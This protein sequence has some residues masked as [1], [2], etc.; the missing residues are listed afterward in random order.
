MGA[1]L[2]RGTSAQPPVVPSKGP[3]L[4]KVCISSWATFGRHRVPGSLADFQCLSCKNCKPVHYE[5]PSCCT[6]HS[7][8]DR[9]CIH[10]VISGRMQFYIQ[11]GLATADD[12]GSSSALINA[13]AAPSE[14]TLQT[15]ERLQIRTSDNAGVAASKLPSSMLCCF[16]SGSNFQSLG[17]PKFGSL[18]WQGS[19]SF[20]FLTRTLSGSL[21]P[22][23][24]TEMQGRLTVVL[25]LDGAQEHHLPDISSDP[26]L[27]G[28][29]V[30]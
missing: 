22:P 13:D 30:K 23:M 14:H 17:S 28:R 7:A 25:D 16:T 1:A 12:E 9:R 4:P 8:T 21:L 3:A 26:D 18:L 20:K 19:G 24:D 10:I 5:M 11:D 2:G 6:E 29:W 27:S 15:E